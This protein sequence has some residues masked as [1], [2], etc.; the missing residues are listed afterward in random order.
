M[1]DPVSNTLTDGTDASSA[2]ALTLTILQLDRTGA[3]WSFEKVKR[4]QCRMPGQAT[5]SEPSIAIPTATLLL[6][7]PLMPFS[8]PFS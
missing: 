2:Q 7:C 1:E 8:P 3:T 5:A 4:N 6:G